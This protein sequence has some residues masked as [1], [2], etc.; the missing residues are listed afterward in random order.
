MIFKLNETFPK[1]KSFK[2]YKKIFR[3]DIHFD[4]NVFRKAVHQ[5][6]EFLEVRWFY[7]GISIKASQKYYISKNKE[8]S[9]LQI[10]QMDFSDAGIYAIQVFAR[11]SQPLATLNIQSLTEKLFNKNIIT[12]KSFLF[13]FV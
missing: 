5:A 8:V 3:V 9:T 6:F 13:I 4:N 1:F 10:N 2:K 7:N 12:L 11:S